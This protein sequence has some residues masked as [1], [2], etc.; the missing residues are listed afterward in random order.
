MSYPAGL[1]TQTITG[2]FTDLV[3]DRATSTYNT[4][5][6]VGFVSLSPGVSEIRYNNVVYDLRDLVNSTY[7]LDE[8]GSFS[9]QIIVTNQSGIEPNNTWAYTLKLSW[10]P[11]REIKIYPT[12]PGATVNISN[13]IVPDA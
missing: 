4:A 10:L 11:G 8:N 1:Q 5:P 12:L 3:F 7:K 6:K 2:T 13:V 9:A